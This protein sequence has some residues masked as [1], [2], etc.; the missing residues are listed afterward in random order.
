MKF[1]S[2]VL[3]I[4]L[5]LFSFADS[6]SQIISI[7]KVNC[8]VSEGDLETIKKIA[9][10]EKD[11][12]NNLFNTHDNDSLLINVSILSTSDYKNMA[13]KSRGLHKTW[14]FYSPSEDHSYVWKQPQ[15]LGTVIHEM[16][17]CLLRHNLNNPPRWLNEG[18]AEFCGSMVIDG[19]KVSYMPDAQSIRTVRNMVLEKPI[20]L[21]N[22]IEL[23]Q[24]NWSDR[25]IRSNLYSISYA[26][27][28][29]LIK[30]NPSLLKRTL[31]LMKDGNSATDAIDHSYGGFNKFENDFNAFY[32]STLIKPI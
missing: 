30:K 23:E 1:R 4:I 31:L 20:D 25:E 12:Y 29:F 27:V 18:I 6:F 2:P 5:L 24:S 32:R 19:D 22:F 26:I 11:L 13:S 16:S 8:R 7:E 15:Y 17:H 10:F 21:N 9:K 14:G 28:Y 3:I